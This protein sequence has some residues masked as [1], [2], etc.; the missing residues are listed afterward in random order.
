MD[1]VC[2]AKTGKFPFKKNSV[3]IL[4]KPVFIK[5]KFSVVTEIWDLNNGDSRVV[6]PTLP[7]S[8]YG[9]GMA[10]YLVPVGFCS[11][12][13][14]ATTN[15]DPCLSGTHTC[16][17]EATCNPY[18][19]NNEFDCECNSGFLGDGFDCTDINECALGQNDCDA[20][21]T[22]I[23]TIG[24]YSCTCDF[25]YEWDG[26]QCSAS[27][28]V[29]VLSTYYPSN[30]PMLV[31]FEGKSRLGTVTLTDAAVRQRYLNC[32]NISKIIQG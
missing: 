1:K 3:P 30:K 6:N 11:T 15:A 28:A 20:H 14:T 23:N 16:H 2:L 21:A 31:G 5:N 26:N 10:L 9:W 12:A 17:V 24:S 32:H 19:T 22:C 13:T 7:N 4:S 18:N 27:H 25:G 29:L 8:D